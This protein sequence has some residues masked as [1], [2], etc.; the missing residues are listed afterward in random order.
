MGLL[1]KC[2]I[3][4]CLLTL[5]T[6]AAQQTN[7]DFV[8]GERDYYQQDWDGAISNFS[9]TIDAGYNLHD[10]YSYRAYSLAEKGD[11][12]GAVADCGRM[13]ALEPNQAGPYYWRA[14]VEIV[15]TNYGAAMRDFD[16]GLKMD[17]ISRPADLAWIFSNTW[18]R[19]A[20]EKLEMTN[21][22][23]AMLDFN[24]A[25]RTD[26]T[27]SYAYSDRGYTKLTQG[28]FDRAIAD[29]FV[30]TKYDPKNMDAYQII[31]WARYERG[32][33][34]GASEACD[35]CIE[36][37]N[38]AGTLQIH[39]S[40]YEHWI[41]EGLASFISG[42]FQKAAEDWNASIKSSDEENGGHT[43][44]LFRAFLY[45]WIEKAKTKEFETKNNLVIT[46]NSSPP[47]DGR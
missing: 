45:S 10:S 26:P 42:D 27:N 16:I 20:F 33:V 18:V 37:W 15:F 7:P 43:P 29:A 30:A 8:A 6:A 39:S 1:H 3:V 22:D 35:K 47:P 34:S 9:E 14:R 31:A 23:A 19:R 44:P 25:V 2:L 12:N 40:E 28:H 11:T 38:K 13:V 32:D 24:E 5:T 46:T 21:T 36:I 41:S 4:S 17:P